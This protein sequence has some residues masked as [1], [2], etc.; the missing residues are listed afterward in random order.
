MPLP[1]ILAGAQFAGGLAQTLFS[2]KRKAQRELEQANSQSP[3]YNGGQGIQN[4]YNQALARASGNPY[5]SALYS[6]AMQNA[7]RTTNQGLSA[8]Q[9]RRSALAGIGKLAAIQD[10]A[11]LRAGIAAENDQ[12][13][14][15]GVLGHAAGMAGAEDKYRY[16][17]NSLN[18]YLRRLSLLQQKAAGSANIFNAGLSNMFGAAQSAAMLS[19]GNK[20]ATPPAKNDAWKTTQQD[21]GFEDPATD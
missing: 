13:K 6:T 19:G 15:F 1:L 2:G 3:T 18:P 5:N 7:Q 8:L 11:Q 20:G 14:K 16:T 4:Y 10:D 9:D 21:D 12:A 17:T